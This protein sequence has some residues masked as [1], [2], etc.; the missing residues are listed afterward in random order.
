MRGTCC[1]LKGYVKEVQGVTTKLAGMWKVLVVI[2]VGER[3][4]AMAQRVVHQV[5]ERLA[6]G[7]VPR[8]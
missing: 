7:C 3:T 6:P 1:N 8:C 2:D 4:L 5:V